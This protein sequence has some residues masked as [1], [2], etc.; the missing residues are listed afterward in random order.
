MISLPKTFQT[1]FKDL[2]TGEAKWINTSLRYV[3]NKY[4]KAAAEKEE[5]IRQLFRRSKTDYCEIFTDEG[6]IKPLMNL[7][8][9]R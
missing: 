1:R 7:F 4:E 2:E 9:N 6:Y 5:E 3:R 8:K